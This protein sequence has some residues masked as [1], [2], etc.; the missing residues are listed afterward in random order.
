MFRQGFIRADETDLN[1][2]YVRH[3]AVAN[4]VY[5]AALANIIVVSVHR[6]LLTSHPLS[7]NMLDSGKSELRLELASW[8]S[9]TLDIQPLFPSASTSRRLLEPRENGQGQ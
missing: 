1:I 7:P 8:V 2:H 9:D 6:I 4:W 3:G 5:F